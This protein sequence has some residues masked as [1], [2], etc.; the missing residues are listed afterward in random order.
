MKKIE[1]ARIGKDFHENK[2]TKYCQG[3]LRLTKEGEAIL[4]GEAL[5]AK[6]FTCPDCGK[7]V[8]FNELEYWGEDLEELVADEVTCSRC[9]EDEMGEDL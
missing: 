7:K 2:Y 1:I 9:Y 8:S 5:N 3:P 4:N 6:V